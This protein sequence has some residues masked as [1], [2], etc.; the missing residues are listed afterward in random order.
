MKLT[1]RDYSEIAEA[2]RRGERVVDVAARFGISKSRASFIARN[3]AG[4]R[5]VTKK[6]MIID[7]AQQHPNA[8]QDEIVRVTGCNPGTVRA[9]LS[10]AGLTRKSGVAAL[11]RAARQAGLSISDIRAIAA[12]GMA[13]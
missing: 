12:R 3:W 5:P 6:Q 9:T 4:V 2:R 8:S 1:K 11:G 13:Q 7:Y 10:L